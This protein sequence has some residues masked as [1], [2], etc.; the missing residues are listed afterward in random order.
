MINKNWKTSYGNQNHQQM[1]GEIVV[2]YFNELGDM[3]IDARKSGIKIPKYSI[4]VMSVQ[5]MRDIGY[6]SNSL[7]GKFDCDKESEITK[8]LFNKSRM[9]YREYFDMIYKTI[10]EEIDGGL[11]FIPHH[12]Q[13]FHTNNVSNVLTFEDLYDF[14]Q[15]ANTDDIGYH[16]LNDENSFKIDSSKR[17]LSICELDGFLG[18]ASMADFVFIPG[19]DIVK[20]HINAYEHEYLEHKFTDTI[21]EALNSDILINDKKEN[22]KNL[23]TEIMNIMIVAIS[24]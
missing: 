7:C 16:K 9:S 2:D 8:A 22:R 20:I 12:I 13:K 14:I 3:L 23:L 10:C 11:V 15:I 21:E 6:T 17:L 4:S 1:I 19:A 18:I 24:K 5:N